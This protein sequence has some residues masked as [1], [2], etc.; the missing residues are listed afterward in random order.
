MCPPASEP[1]KS[2]S[3]TPAAPKNTPDCVPTDTLSRHAY[4]YA[5]AALH[6]A[7][8]NHSLRTYLYAKAIA[9]RENSPWAS[10]DRLH[11]LFAT[12]IYHDIGTC[13]GA[14][15]PQRFEVEGAEKGVSDLR[16]LNVSEADAHEVW[17]AIAVHT[18]PHIAERISPLARLLRLAVLVDFQVS[19]QVAEFT[20][21]AAVE[22]NEC[23]FPRL[24]AAKVLG[25]LVVGQAIN[26]PEKG[27]MASWVGVM[28]RSKVEN[29]EWDGVNKEF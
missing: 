12:C 14:D 29:P 6:P 13:C 21:E 23:E 1:A 9:E 20:S 28:V 10:P 22:A 4:T 3:S 15:S 26:V 2:P 5:S 19:A 27:R 7:I 17:V 8:L 24:D 18:S 25:D 11:L 16:S